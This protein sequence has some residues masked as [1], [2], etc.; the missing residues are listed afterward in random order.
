MNEPHVYGMWGKVGS[1]LNKPGKSLSRAVVF[2][3]WPQQQQ[4][5][6]T[7]L[8]PLP[9]MHLLVS[10]SQEKKYVWNF[11][12][13]FFWFWCDIVE[14]LVWM[15]ERER[16]AWLGEHEGAWV[17]EHR[18]RRWRVVIASVTSWTLQHKLGIYLASLDLIQLYLKFN[19]FFFLTWHISIY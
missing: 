3:L 18:G 13:L 5:S 2:N 19:S 14:I 8:C 7:D 17:V 1:N 6:I 9:A 15:R 16:V 11:R 10:L 12:G 4:L